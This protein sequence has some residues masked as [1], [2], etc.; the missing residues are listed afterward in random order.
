M[1]AVG[2]SLLLGGIEDA[3]S[4]AIRQNFSLTPIGLQ[5]FLLN[6]KHALEIVDIFARP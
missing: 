5:F 4:I 2:F 6:V 1:R 3:T